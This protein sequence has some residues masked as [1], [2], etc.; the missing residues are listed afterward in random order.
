MLAFGQRMLRQTTKKAFFAFSANSAVKGLSIFS[1]L[2]HNHFRSCTGC[3][4]GFCRGH[5]RSR[6]ATCTVKEEIRDQC[7]RLLPKFVP[8][9]VGA[10]G[11]LLVQ[12]AA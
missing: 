5:L 10:V 12:I 8:Y 6:A 9:A 2:L 4:Q 3:P 7:R 1:S 11:S